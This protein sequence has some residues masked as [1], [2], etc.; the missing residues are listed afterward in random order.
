MSL[1]VHNLT[2]VISEKTKQTEFHW[3]S[4]HS[5]KGGWSELKMTRM[6]NGFVCTKSMEIIIS[7]G[8]K[9]I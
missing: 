6:E 9:G 2:T 3:L 8:M 5:K 1:L 4:T 7:M